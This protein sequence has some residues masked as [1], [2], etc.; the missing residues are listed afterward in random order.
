MVL[1]P[2]AA[3][4]KGL[5]AGFS[6]TPRTHTHTHQNIHLSLGD[7]WATPCILSD[8]NYTQV[9]LKKGSPKCGVSIRFPLTT[10]NGL[11]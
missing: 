9:C 11:S 5:V 6:A 4:E 10:P 1:L 2:P 8:A 3:T 7:R